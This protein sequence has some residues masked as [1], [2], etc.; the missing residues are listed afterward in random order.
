M[1]VVPPP[2]P[3]PVVRPLAADSW[4]VQFTANNLFRNK[5]RTVQDLLRLLCHAHNQ[6]AAEL[7]YGRAKMEASRAAQV[8]SREPRLL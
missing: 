3:R 7:V 5:L 8:T 6:H 2:P 4:K 1:T